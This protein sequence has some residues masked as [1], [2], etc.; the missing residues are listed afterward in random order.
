MSEAAVLEEAPTP[1]L[2]EYHAGQGPKINGQKSGIIRRQNAQK[3]KDL[4]DLLP[5]ILPSLKDRLQTAESYPEHVQIRMSRIEGHLE[6]IDKAMDTCSTAADWRDL[7][8]ARDKLF[9]AWAH[10]AGI[11]KPMAPREVRSARPRY[12]YMPAA[13][14]EIP[15]LPV[16]VMD[17]SKYRVT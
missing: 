14:I 17:T 16:E 12:Q 3:L 7:S 15:S 2:S 1:Y 11:P 4:T 6:R 5:A 13:P 8:A 9:Q 10:L